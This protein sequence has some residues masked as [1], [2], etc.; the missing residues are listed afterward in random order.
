MAANQTLIVNM[1]YNTPFL[2]HVPARPD[3]ATGASLWRKIMDALFSRTPV[4]I[5][6]PVEIYRPETLTA[7]LCRGPLASNRTKIQLLAL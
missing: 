7:E 3:A 5:Q 6:A 1:A 2:C 4:W